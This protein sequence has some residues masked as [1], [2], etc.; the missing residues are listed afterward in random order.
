MI[1]VIAAAFMAGA[2]WQMARVAPEAAGGLDRLTRKHLREA[3][4]L[5]RDLLGGSAR[6]NSAGAPP[7]LHQGRSEA[8]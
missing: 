5:A 2:N 4:H 8:R 3:G 7:P 6:A 1:E